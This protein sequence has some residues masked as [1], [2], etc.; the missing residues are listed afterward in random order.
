MRRPIAGCCCT[1]SAIFRVDTVATADLRERCGQTPEAFAASS[2]DWGAYLALGYKLARLRAA[3]P[4]H[5]VKSR[6]ADR[7][8]AQANGARFLADDTI[9]SNIDFHY[10]V[11]AKRLR[12]AELSQQRRE[13]PPGG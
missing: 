11:L 1:T 2:A 9:F 8:P 13:D 7:A 12:R 10:D 5:T 4:N 3:W 6:P